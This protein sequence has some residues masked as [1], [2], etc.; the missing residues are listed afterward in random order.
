MG[1]V[2]E[3]FVSYSATADKSLHTFFNEFLPYI[4]LL[5]YFRKDMQSMLHDPRVDLRTEGT[6]FLSAPMIN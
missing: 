3:Y 2:I 6:I 4:M 1:P 5:S